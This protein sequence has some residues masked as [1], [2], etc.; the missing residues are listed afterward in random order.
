[1][2]NNTF[3]TIFRLT[4]FGESHGSAI[5]GIIDGMPSGISIDINF[6][7][8]EL[9]RRKP[10]QSKIT[11]KRKEEDKIEILS[12]IL[13]GKTTGTP[14]AFIIKNEDQIS[15]DYNTIKDLYRPSHA[16]Y[17]YQQKYGIRDYRGGGRSSARITIAR[18]VA[19]AFAKMA[20]KEINVEIKSYVS[21]IGNI[22]IDKTYL[23]LDLSNIEN[24]S[25]RCPDSIKG[26]DM[27]KLILECQ[28]K[29]DSIG[30]A[31]TCVIKNCP[32]G[33]GEPE[34]NKLHAQL[35]FAMLS[36]N[37]CKGFEYGQG[38]KSARMTGKEFND[39]LCYKEGKVY[40]KTNNNGGI[41]GGISNGEDIYFN[42]VFKP[43][44][45]IMA[46][47]KTI[48]TEH[49][50]IKFKA[51]GRHDPCVVPRAISIVEAMAAIVILDNYLLNKTIKL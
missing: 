26:A 29:G 20:L 42:V 47:Q 3:G 49:K 4:S 38:F 43:T 27:E 41:L 39:E 25:V 17:T 30:G 19:G 35:A 14:I 12:G 18:V 22:K 45:T 15:K 8:N 31:I 28:N 1:M 32:K 36:I 24:N 37:A 33:L 5:G 40:T 50:N 9:N 51:K 6:I 2:S 44:P 13:E 21:Q 23:D 10:G 11:T 7:Q 34:F 48:T 16:D 46:E